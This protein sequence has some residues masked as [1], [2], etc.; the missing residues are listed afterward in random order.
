MKWSKKVTR[1]IKIQCIGLK[2]L[3]LPCGRNRR[4]YVAYS[5]APNF[6]IIVLKDSQTMEKGREEGGQSMVSWHNQLGPMTHLRELIAETPDECFLQ[7]DGEK[8]CLISIISPKKC[9]CSG[10]CASS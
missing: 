8:D 1:I 5:H 2:A 3:S 10:S 9:H 4:H 6:T 7:E